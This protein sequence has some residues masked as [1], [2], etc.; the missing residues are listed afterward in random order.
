MFH[1]RVIY[2]TGMGGPALLSH[3]NRS[4]WSHRQA[5]RHAA[6]IRAG[7]TGIRGFLRVEIVRA[8]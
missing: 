7:R 8:S 3:R 5:Q 6:D 2:T 1:V 4:S